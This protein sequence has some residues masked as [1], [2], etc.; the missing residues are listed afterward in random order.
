M[1]KKQEIHQ[2]I[3]KGS[4][5][6][7]VE[8]K[9]EDIFVEQWKNE[10]KKEQETI[11]KRFDRER[12]EW[13]RKIHDMSQKLKKVFEI[14]DLLTNIYTE[15]Q[16]AIEY[17]HYL[18]TLMTRVNR[19][20]R[21]QYAQKYEHY[22]FQTQKRFPNETTKNNQILSEMEEVVLKKES[23]ANHAKFME[24]TTKT[25]DNLIFGIK[26]RIEIEQMSRGK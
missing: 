16:R 23:L 11:E 15:R 12:L 1:S 24:D 13:T 3:I 14:Q 2:P 26:Y 7:F 10:E 21:K 18:L 6:E 8:E 25:I 9:K 5:E 19:T 4:F 22:S 17:N 20:Y